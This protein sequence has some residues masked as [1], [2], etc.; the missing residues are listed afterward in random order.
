MKGK[1]FYVLCWHCATRGGQLAFALFSSLFS[2]LKC[3]RILQSGVLYHISHEGPSWHGA[4]EIRNTN[5]QV[6][7]GITSNSSCV[8]QVQWIQVAECELSEWTRGEPSGADRA[9]RL[10]GRGGR[11][12]GG[13][14]AWNYVLRDTGFAA[15]RCKE[16]WWYLQD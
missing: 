6:T 15:L 16:A 8:M 1:Y 11:E 12:G 14:E 9:P 13:G 5:G 2:P 4:V 10:T 7:C 3:L